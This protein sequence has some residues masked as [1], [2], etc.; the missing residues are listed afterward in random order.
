MTPERRLRALFK[1]WTPKL[2]LTDWD[3][4]IEL[5][6][7]LPAVDSVVDTAADCHAIWEYE[8]ATIRFAEEYVETCDDSM[9]ENH[10]V[11]ELMHVM[12]NELRREHKMPNEER[13]ATRLTRAFLR[14]AA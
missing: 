4:A 7:P 6:P 3:I 2:G 8:R 13:T 14:V 12:L 5:A 1:K 9:L 11:H 10:V